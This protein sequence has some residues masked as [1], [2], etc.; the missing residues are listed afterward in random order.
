MEVEKILAL[1]CFVYSVYM[2]K[3]ANLALALGSFYNIAR[4]LPHLIPIGVIMV[5][6]STYARLC[7][8]QMT[9]ANQVGKRARVVV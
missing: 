3:V 4:V 5:H 2:Q 9:C 1:S 8:H 7:V 6:F